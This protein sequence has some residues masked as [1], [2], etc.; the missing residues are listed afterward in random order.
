MLS[1]GLPHQPSPPRPAAVHDY[2]LGQNSLDEKVLLR[3]DVQ[4]DGDGDETGSSTDTDS[5]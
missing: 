4:L 3:T 5:D 2:N 1:H